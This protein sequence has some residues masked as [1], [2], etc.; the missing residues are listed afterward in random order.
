MGALTADDIEAAIKTELVAAEAP[1]AGKVTVGDQYRNINNSPEGIRPSH[2]IEAVASAQ[3]EWYGLGGALLGVAVA[4]VAVARP[5]VMVLEMSSLK[6]GEVQVAGAWRLY[7]LPADTSPTRAFAVLLE[8]YAFLGTG[9]DGAET[10][11]VASAH[12]PKGHDG[13]AI[14][15]K[16]V[17]G[18]PAGRAMRV[19]MTPRYNSDGSADIAWSYAFDDTAYLADVRRLR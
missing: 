4:P 14:S 3:A 18:G 17:H 11:F 12:L 15:I 6:P 16:G 2:A 5:Y 7:D 8:R 13:L 19:A 9:P 10:K 1:P